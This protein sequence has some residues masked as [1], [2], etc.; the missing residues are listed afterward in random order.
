MLNPVLSH[1]PK[2][3]IFLEA[4]AVALTQA[5]RLIGEY[6]SKRTQADRE[7]CVCARVCACMCV[8]VCMRAYVC[9][10]VCACVHTC[11]CVRACVCAYLHVCVCV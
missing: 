7:V 6:R 4:K 10:H 5:D 3:V 9:M 8:H 1:R 11:L 2:R